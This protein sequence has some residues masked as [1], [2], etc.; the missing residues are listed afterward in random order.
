MKSFTWSCCSDMI[1]TG[2]YGASV[3][4]LFSEWCSLQR[5]VSWGLN[6]GPNRIYTGWFWIMFYLTSCSWIFRSVSCYFTV[7]FLLLLMKEGEFHELCLIVLF[8]CLVASRFQVWKEVVWWKNIYNLWN[9]RLFSS[10][11]S[12]GKGAWSSCWLVLIHHFIP[13]IELWFKYSNCFI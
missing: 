6:V 10:W 4:H 3:F 13:K 8:C 1:I 9:G 12:S 5:G 11:D 7:N 2:F